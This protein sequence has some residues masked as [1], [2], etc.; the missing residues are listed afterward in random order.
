M[1]A[2]NKAGEAEIDAFASCQRRVTAE[3]LQSDTVPPVRVT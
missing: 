2:S 3:R 1:T